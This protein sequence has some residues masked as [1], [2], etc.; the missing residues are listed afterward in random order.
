MNNF[1]WQYLVGEYKLD[2]PVTTP[3][4][5]EQLLD[6]PVATPILWEQLLD[7]PVATPI[8]WEQLLDLPAWQYHYGGREVSTTQTGDLQSLQSGKNTDNKLHL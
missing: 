7:L 6:L 3:N 5:W 2:F 1:K 4:L 8:L